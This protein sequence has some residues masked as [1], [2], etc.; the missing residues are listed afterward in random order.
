MLKESRLNSLCN[1]A[2]TKKPEIAVRKLVR[3]LLYEYGS[4]HPPFTSERFCEISN[5]KIEKTFLVDCDARLLP[6]R[7]GY[8]AEVSAE[9]PKIRQ[10]FSLCHEVGHTF[11]ESGSTDSFPEPLNCFISPSSETR[12]E[13]KL[14]NFAAAEMLMPELVF[15]KFVLDFQPSLNSI[16]LIAKTFGTSAQAV[17]NRI[18]EFDLWQIMVAC[19]YPTDGNYAELGFSVLWWRASSSAFKNYLKSDDVVYCL[20]NIPY[21]PKL[22]KESGVLECFNSGRQTQGELL[23]Q[24]LKKSFSMQSFK[25]YQNTAPTVFSIV[26]RENL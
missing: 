8:I 10:N 5:V 16:R 1:R 4:S 14:C 17:I 13:E 19:Y 9:H 22:L 25:V 11:F 2:K 12:L 18:I 6:I 21:S 23:I 15:R 3:K 26:I 20:R 7:G 24:P